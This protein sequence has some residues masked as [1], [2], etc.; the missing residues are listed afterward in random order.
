[1]LSTVEDVIN[2]FDM[3]GE[4]EVYWTLY[5]GHEIKASNLILRNG[6]TETK[7]LSRSML[8]D[9]L[10][11]QSVRGGRFYLFVTDK[12]NGNAGPSTLIDIIHGIGANQ[13]PQTHLGNLPT[14]DEARLRREIEQ[15][16]RIKELERKLNEDG[17]PKNPYLDAW[18]NHPVTIPSLN[19]IMA[20]VAQIFGVPIPPPIPPTPPAI[21]GTSAQY[22]QAAKPKEP[23]AKEEVEEEGYDGP[24]LYD[25]CS[26]LEKMGLKPEETLKAMVEMLKKKPD[27]L[28]K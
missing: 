5:R 2:W 21:G 7:E 15:E 11:M 26:D 18:F 14:V 22:Q 17:H 4:K 10:R 27:L 12:P 23:P 8:N 28:K 20:G 3:Q 1:M 16:Y 24:T 13:N 9:N 25:V 6:S 19:G